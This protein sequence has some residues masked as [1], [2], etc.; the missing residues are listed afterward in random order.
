MKKRIYL[1]PYSIIVGTEEFPRELLFTA[2]SSTDAVIKLKI[3][4][5]EFPESEYKIGIAKLV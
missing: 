4:L 3:H 2:K 1:V 5:N